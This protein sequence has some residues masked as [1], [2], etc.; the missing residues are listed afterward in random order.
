MI[1]RPDIDGLRALAVLLVVFNHIFAFPTGGY[2]GV[3][4]FFVISGYLITLIIFEE[5]TTNKFSFC[6][7]YA[8]RA[9]RILPALIFMLI[10]VIS[11]AYFILLPSEMKQFGQAL[12]ATAGF[13]ANVY[14]N[15]TSDYF[16][17]AAE[18]APL[19][20]TWSLAVEEQFYFVFPILLILCVRHGRIFTILV[21]SSIF[22]VSLLLSIYYLPTKPAEV[23]YQ[24]PFRVWELLIGAILAI[25]KNVHFFKMNSNSR[26]IL[27]FFSILLILIPAFYY[28]SN[29][30]F[31]GLNAIPPVIGTAGLIW[32]NTAKNENVIYKILSFPPVVW[33]GL[34]SY[35]LYLYHWPVLA[36]TRIS[37][38]SAQLNFGSRMSVLIISVFL[39]TISWFFIEKPFRSYGRNWKQPIVVIFAGL[40]VTFTILIGMSLYYFDGLPS[41]FDSKIAK[42]ASHQYNRNLL[43]VECFN[44]AEFSEKCML[45]ANNL[46]PNG[47]DFILWGDSHA[48]AMALAVDKAAETARKQGLIWAHKACPPIL[49]IERL[50][51][52]NACS[53]FN[54]KVSKLILELEKKPVI[55]LVARWPL[56]V[57]GSRF[58]GEAGKEVFLKRSS[59]LNSNAGVTRSGLK[60]TIN[61]LTDAGHEVVIVESVPEVGFNVPIALA[62]AIALNFDA[63]TLARKDFDDRSRETLNILK[64]VTENPQVHLLQLSDI[65][66]D[67]M[68]CMVVDKAGLPI[69]NDN[70]HIRQGAALDLLSDRF[71]TIWNVR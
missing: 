41:R 32:V 45:G 3:D 14:Y 24:L 70:N 17:S 58:G 10:I 12:V 34:I 19:L 68:Q 39:A 47:P 61:Y 21:I 55:V 2:I 50:I 59:D 48:L 4:V 69:Y 20:H 46:D 31:P 71:T 35:S 25:S 51:N 64:E 66:C 18:F 22:V 67:D 15:A 36:L 5:I 38:D 56:S 11:A 7:F 16:S 40:A 37:L 44:E 1:Y 65:L 27:S 49:G 9:R 54:A 53:E 57:E 63:P 33:I 52:G 30:Q 62:R 8:R 26:N 13:L 60:R 29:T 23:F 43:Y 28:T 42:I 6:D